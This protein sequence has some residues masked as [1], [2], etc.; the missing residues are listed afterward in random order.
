MNTTKKD[1][2]LTHTEQNM[3]SIRLSPDGFSFAVHPAEGKSITLFRHTPANAQRSMAANV[4]SFLT[5]TPE[6]NAGYRQTNILIHTLR[7]TTVPLELFEDEQMETVFYQNLP[8][9]NNEIV[10]CNILGNSNVVVL[11]SI[12][13][14]THV[15]LSEHFPHARFFATVSPQLEYLTMLSKQ[16]GERETYANLH[17]GN[18][19]VFCF[20]HGKLQ[21]SNTYPVN[22]NE[23]R[24]YYLLN[25]WKQLGYDV[26]QDEL[27]LTGLSKEE[28]NG[29][30]GFLRQFIRKIF[31]I[32]PRTGTSDAPESITENIPFDIQSLLI[33]E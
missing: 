8:M 23:D 14:L 32:N 25:L 31:I 30:I 4:K 27:Y 15:F 7:Y 16:K 1:T 17:A 28:R 20:E 13:K 2:D 18:M 24:S 9:R 3:L 19:E 12:D 22:N 6:L 29:L 11:F 26:E 5:Q 10:L 21:L 33:C